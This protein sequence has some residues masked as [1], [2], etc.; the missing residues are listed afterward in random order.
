MQVKN[1]QIRRW[2]LYKLGKL[3]DPTW[4]ITRSQTCSLHQS[5]LSIDPSLLISG[6]QVERTLLRSQ[7][8]ISSRSF[9]PTKT[10]NLYVGLL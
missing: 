10:D 2:L 6:K 1:N 5:G 7:R 9:M 4:T 8:S 3:T